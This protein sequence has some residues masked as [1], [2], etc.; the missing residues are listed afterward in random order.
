MIAILEQTINIPFLQRIRKASNLRRFS[1]EVRRVRSNV[2]PG[3]KIRVVRGDE[4]FVATVL[5]VRAYSHGMTEVYVRRDGP[6]HYMGWVPVDVILPFEEA[7][8]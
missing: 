8:R 5:N 7:V 6:T 3:E 1:D 2:S 4:T